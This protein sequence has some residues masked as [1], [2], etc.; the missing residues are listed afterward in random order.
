MTFHVKRFEPYHIELMRAQ[1]PQEAQKRELSMAGEM[2]QAPPGAA[3]TAFW[4]DRV[5]ICGGII[6]TYPKHG[7]VWGLLG[8]IPKMLMPRIHFGVK[9]FITAREW[10]R[11]EATVELGFNQGCRW[12]ELLGFRREGE[13]PGYGLKGETHVRFG[14]TPWL[15]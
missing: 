5:L 7:I 2:I 12:L 15:S 13:M 1:G 3:V 10:V 9:R 14:R 8:E 4:G 11:L 6:E